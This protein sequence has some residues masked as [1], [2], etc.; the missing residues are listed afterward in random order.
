MPSLIWSQILSGCPSVTDSD[1][2]R[3]AIDS[4]RGCAAAADRPGQST[5]RGRPSG[6]LRPQGGGDLVEHG[7]GDPV[8]PCWSDGAHVLDVGTQQVDGAG[9][10]AEG[11]TGTHLVGHEQVAALALEL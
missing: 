11:H 9:V 1:V 2:N 4:P 6:R 5:V 7:R 8:L 3:R 10:L